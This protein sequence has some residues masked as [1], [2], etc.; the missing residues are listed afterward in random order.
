M[1]VLAVLPPALRFGHGF[2]FDEPTINKEGRPCYSPYLCIYGRYYAGSEP[3]TN[4]EFR[5]LRIDELVLPEIHC[6]RIPNPGGLLTSNQST[7][8]FGTEG[9]TRE[10]A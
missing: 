8:P 5:A 10:A 7:H 6:E 2:L 3:M 4:A 1:D 9:F